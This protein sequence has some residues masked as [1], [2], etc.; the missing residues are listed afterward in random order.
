MG[1]GR[2][3]GRSRSN[4]HRRSRCRLVTVAL[5]AA[6]WASILGLPGATNSGVAASPTATF[7]MHPTHGPS[8][9]VINLS[10]VTPC[11]APIGATNWRV[12]ITQSVQT[13]V[14]T[15]VGEISTAAVGA[16]GD[17]SHSIAAKNGFGTSNDVTAS[18]TDNQGDR[19]DYVA[20]SFT[21]TTAGAGYWLLT[22]GTVL[23]WSQIPTQTNVRE[24][25]DAPHLF[26]SALPFAAPLVGIA[27]NP[28]SG[29]GYWL[30]ASDGGIFSFG[31]AKFLGA[32]EA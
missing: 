20:Q 8:G 15:V 19:L 13:S 17:W 23:G 26:E 24:F 11:P 22:N 27:P 16:G 4:G 18:C 9:T 25:G 5:L 14:D 31:D 28:T 3:L 32:R 12:V 6:A 30:V 2:R 10:S 21:T 7:S 1:K 29:D